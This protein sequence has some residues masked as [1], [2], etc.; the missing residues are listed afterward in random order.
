MQAHRHFYAQNLFLRETFAQNNF[1]QKTFDTE[2]FVHTD[3][4]QIFLQ[5]DFSARRKFTQSNFCT[6]EPFSHRNIY[7]QKNY[8]LQFLHADGFYMKRPPSSNPRI[9][10]EI[11]TFIRLLARAWARSA[12]VHAHAATVSGLVHRWS[13][14]LSHA[15]HHAFAPS[16]LTD[17]LTATTRWEA[18]PISD[19]ITHIPAPPTP[20]RLAFTP[21]ARVWIYARP[22]FCTSGG[23][24][25]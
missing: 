3:C 20:S 15:A 9:S 17:N 11:A 23:W 1:A 5:T 7:A 12:P 13:A 16:L 2:K 10:N 14:L 18:P 21:P 24:P 22:S 8:A 19:I 25:V 6:A 4:A